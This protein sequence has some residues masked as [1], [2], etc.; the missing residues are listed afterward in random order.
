MKFLG[1][2]KADGSIVEGTLMI[3][4]LEAWIATPTGRTAVW[5]DTV[6]EEVKNE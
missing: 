5:P 1:K 3:E 4:G 6:E 2:S